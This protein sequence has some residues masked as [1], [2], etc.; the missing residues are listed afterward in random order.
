[1]G[2]GFPQRARSIA[3]STG[4]LIAAVVLAAA[5]PGDA[6]PVDWSSAQ[7]VEVRMVEYAFVPN[8]LRL[9]HGVPYQFHL[10]NAGKEG[11]DFTA[12]DFFA[13][14]HVKNP[15]ALNN[16]NSIYL[17]P[18]AAA[19]IYLIAPTVGLFGLRCADHDWA[20]M[21]ATIVFD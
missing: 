18:G 4:A 13:A 14:V 20:G 3:V 9:H 10:V 6:A 21:T 12:A 19:D 7:R 11:H 2:T 15:E 5:R 17:T 16:G 8:A 1:V